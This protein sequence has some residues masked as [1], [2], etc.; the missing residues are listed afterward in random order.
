MTDMTRSSAAPRANA[1]NNATPES[2]TKP[3]PKRHRLLSTP[4]IT[5]EQCADEY[6]DLIMR[7]TRAE[8]GGRFWGQGWDEPLPW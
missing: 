5:P 1:N 7:S 3:A 8:H 4:R 2:D 6:V